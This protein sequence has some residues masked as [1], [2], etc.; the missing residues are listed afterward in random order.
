[1]SNT[2]GESQDGDHHQTSP[3]GTIPDTTISGRADQ[4]IERGKPPRQ[5]GGRG[6]IRVTQPACPGDGRW[7]FGQV[8]LAPWTTK[9][10]RREE[11]QQRGG[12]SSR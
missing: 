11:R 7:P 4:H 6:D 10:K 12:C 3:R 9:K 8:D 5:L 1:M 2:S